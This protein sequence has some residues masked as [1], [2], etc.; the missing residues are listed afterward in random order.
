MAYT[1][2]N[3]TDIEAGKAVKEELWQTIKDNQDSFNTDIEALKQTSVIDI[4][5]T[6]FNGQINEYSISEI[7]ERVPTFK[8]PVAAT[9]TSFI[10]TLLTA[11]TSGTLEIEVDRSTD[12][13]I[14][15]SP[16]LSTPVELTGITVGSVSGTVNWIDVPSQSFNQN[17]LI[18]MRITGV[19]VDQGDFHLS[20]YGE[21][22]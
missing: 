17:D 14:N 6:K 19:Q 10:I 15:W 16:L 9:F 18:R 1:P 8:A 2:L 3:I 4:F 22:S 5:D 13:G 20:I 12:N 21:L 11:S 7:N